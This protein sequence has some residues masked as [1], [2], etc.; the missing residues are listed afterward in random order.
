[1]VQIRKRESFLIDLRMS[2]KVIIH[3]THEEAAQYVLEQ[4]FKRT[5]EERIKWLLEMNKRMHR[6]NP[7]KKHFKGMVLRLKNG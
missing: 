4:G 5:P 6:F 7:V 1:M 2:K 3:K